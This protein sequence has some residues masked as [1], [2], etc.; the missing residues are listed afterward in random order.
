MCG[1]AGIF[2]FDE[3]FADVS[4]LKNAISCLKQRGPDASGFYLD[5]NI[6]LGHS[7]LAIIDLDP[8]SNQPFQDSSG[9]Y[10]LIFNGEIFNYQLLK[11][12]LQLSGTHFRTE[13]DTEVLL[14][15]LINEG[16]KCLDSLNGFFAFAFYDRLTQ[17]LI[18]ARDKYGVKPLYIYKNENYIAFA[19]ELKALIKL[20]IPK[21]IDY[22]SLFIYLQLT[23]LPA[24]NCILEGVYKLKQAHCLSV[25]KNG[26]EDFQKY[27]SLLIKES[28]ENYDTKKQ[29]LD[30]LLDLAVQDRLVSDVPVGV[31]LSGGVDSSI[32]SLLAKRHK[33]DIQSFS[34]GFKGDKSFDES[35]YAE[36]VAKLLGLEHYTLHLTE[37][38]LLE[39][40]ERM[41]EYTDEPFADSSAIAV[42]NLCLQTRNFATV[43]L[44]GDGADEVF[45]GYN[46]HIAEMKIRNGGIFTSIASKIA[47]F[48]K[49]LPE[50]RGANIGNALRKV[51]KY[52]SSA[53]LSVQERYW[54]WCCFNPEKSVLNSLSPFTNSK[55]SASCF[56]TFKKD[57]TNQLENYNLNYLLAADIDMVLEGDMLVKADRMS[58]ANSMELRNPFLDS[59]VV[60]F[61]FTLSESDKVSGSVAKKIL[62]DTFRSYL[63][64]AV[65]DRPK[66]GFEVPLTKW[67]QNDLSF[68]IVKYLNTELVQEQ[69]IFSSQYINELI[70]KLNSSKPDNSA[71]QIWTILNFQIWFFKMLKVDGEL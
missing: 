27:Y 55:L 51:K 24:T 37:N 6:A 26:K 52:S 64:G 16:T 71:T 9:R 12:D 32:V 1:I 62:K 15:L 63:P 47:P 49:H 44:T 20:G 54:S 45:G 57:K 5:K 39:N 60:D 17:K 58:M 67:L 35:K 11:R 61:A 30:T 42:F 69:N 4:A 18:L 48:L 34:I 3:E 19:S 66:R 50:S 43:A 53:S 2:R 31:F 41:L 68:L 14:H 36:N 28:K 38:L 8:A 46:K 7:R 25:D 23:Y 22:D 33:P 56:K 10:T 21:K 13:S 70:V 40:V 65:F 59:R 29:K